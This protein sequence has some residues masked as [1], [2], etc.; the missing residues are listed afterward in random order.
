MPYG[1]VVPRVG[2]IIKLTPKKSNTTQLF[3][4]TQIVH[5]IRRRVFGEGQKIKVFVTRVQE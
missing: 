1:R 3:R 2:G 5:E 4:V